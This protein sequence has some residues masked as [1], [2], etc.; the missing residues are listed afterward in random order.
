MACTSRINEIGHVEVNNVVVILIYGG[1]YSRTFYSVRA[2]AI[3]L[4]VTPLAI[5]EAFYLGH[6]FAIVLGAS[7]APELRVLVPALLDRV[8]RLATV[9][10]LANDCQVLMGYPLFLFFIHDLVLPECHRCRLSGKIRPGKL[11]H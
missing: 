4:D 6:A 7:L 9:A 2:G 11:I 10:T 8:T 1:N 5:L 3:P